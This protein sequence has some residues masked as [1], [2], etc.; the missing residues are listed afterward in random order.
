MSRPGTS[1]LT[2]LMATT[3][4]G[5]G[6]SPTATNNGAEA[7]TTASVATPADIALTPKGA[8]R[9]ADGFWEMASFAEDGSPMS[10]QS[11]CVGAGSED[12]FSVFDQLAIMGNCSKQDF[13]RNASGWTFETRCALMD[14]VTVQKGTI[15]GDFQQSFLID[16]T[17]TQNPDT[18][19]KGQIRGK[20][21][22]ACPAKF[23][24]GDLVDKDG[25]VLG[26]M[27]G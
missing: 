22:G 7:V 23:K 15:S 11:L 18:V 6:Q 8:P 2:F 20:H 5:C 12:K 3:L 4:A 19:R 17:V 16:Q 9:R 25:G 24:P 21:V 14:T 26:N 1:I 10:K 27:L 13:Q